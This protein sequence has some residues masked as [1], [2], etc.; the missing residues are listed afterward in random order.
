MSTWR[1]K[2]RR[3]RLR[4]GRVL[5]GASFRGVP[6][7]VDDSEREGGRRTVPHQFPFR[8]RP[9]IDDLGRRMRV[10]SVEGYVLGEDYVAQRDQLLDALENQAGP[11]ELVHPYHGVRRAICSQLQVRES[12]LEGRMARFTL[13]F[14]EAEDVSTPTEADDA[15]Q[16][17]DASADAVVEASTDELEDSLSVEG[18]PSFALAS[19]TDEVRGVSDAMDEALAPLVDAAQEWA[20]IDQELQAISAEAESLIRSPRQ[21]VDALVGA[22]RSTVETAADIPRDIMRALLDSYDVRSP[23]SAIG[24][25]DTRK[26]ERDNQSAVGDGVRRVM[27]AEAARLAPRVDHDSEDDAISDRDRILERIDEQSRTSGPATYAALVQLRADVTRAVPGNR[28]LARIVTEQRNEPTPALV[29]SYQLY[30]HTR[31]E[32]DI[33]RRN[34]L[35]HPGFAVGRLRV[36]SDG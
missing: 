33:V 3:V 8:D 31:N 27:L 21:L 13:E 35:Q 17:T 22:M 23:P 10:F 28:E 4:D 24:D 30:G 12:R 14:Q 2:L 1:D 6:F 7:F 25:T 9:Y 34:R 11:G 19:V 32:R 20:R 5:I 16:R 26:T 18:Q 15:P 36:L 29:L